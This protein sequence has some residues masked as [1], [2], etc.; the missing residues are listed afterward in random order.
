MAQDQGALEELQRDE[1][2]RKRFLKMVGGAGAAGA[3]GI[4]IAA[5]GDDDDEDGVGPRAGTPPPRAWTRTGATRR[6]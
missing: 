6:S 5:C 3:L 2:S 1:S 4:F